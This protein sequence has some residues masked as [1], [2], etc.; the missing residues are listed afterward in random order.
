MNSAAP[1]VL[2]YQNRKTHQPTADMAGRGAH[3]AGGASWKQPD[4]RDGGKVAWQGALGN[5]PLLLDGP[6]GFRTDN[7]R[8]EFEYYADRLSPRLAKDEHAR[9]SAGRCVVSQGD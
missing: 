6:I 1:A 7:A 9:N 3:S 5:E 8:F 4:G 2:E